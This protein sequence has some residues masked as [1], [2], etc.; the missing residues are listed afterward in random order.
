MSRAAKGVG[1]AKRSWCSSSSSRRSS[2]SPE[3]SIDDEAVLALVL[4]VDKLISTISSGV[5]FGRW[6][7]VKRSVADGESG[8]RALGMEP[9]STVS[10]IGKACD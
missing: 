9:L 2:G 5:G 6:S 8:D 4:F 10:K 7:G 1:G 3:R